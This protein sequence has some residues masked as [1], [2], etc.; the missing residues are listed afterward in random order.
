MSEVSEDE[1]TAWICASTQFPVLTHTC[2]GV[3]A[4]ATLGDEALHQL[5][6]S[7]DIQERLGSMLGAIREESQLVTV[8]ISYIKC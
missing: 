8:S 4:M 6:I 1:G 2:I 3:V 5:Q 7:G